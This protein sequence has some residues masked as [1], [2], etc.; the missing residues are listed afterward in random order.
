[1]QY[2]F[3]SRLDTVEE[4][5]FELEASSNKYKVKRGEIENEKSRKE[6]IT[7]NYGIKA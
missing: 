7:Y 3:K 6:K 1:M 5:V 4:C 2:I